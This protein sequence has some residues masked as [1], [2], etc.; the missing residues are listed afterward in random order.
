MIIEDSQ[1]IQTKVNRKTS[2]A[3]KFAF[4]LRKNLFSEIFLLNEEELDILDP[5]I[6]NKILKIV[7]VYN[8]LS[9]S[10]KLVKLFFI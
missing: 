10:L 8:L 2:F 5:L 3:R 9:F 4:E 1:E 6:W 7:K